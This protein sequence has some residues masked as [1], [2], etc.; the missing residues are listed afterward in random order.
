MRTV[1]PY[2]S[3]LPNIAKLAVINNG[4]PKLHSLNLGS[5]NTAPGNTCSKTGAVYAPYIETTIAITNPAIGPAI[6]TS[7]KISRLIVS[8]FDWINA[9]NVGIPITG[10]PGIK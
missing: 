10:N 3:P 6:A 9:P 7:N 1:F 5:S 8:P 4:S 2:M